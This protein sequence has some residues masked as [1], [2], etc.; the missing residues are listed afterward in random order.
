MKLI[1]L[2]LLTT[3]MTVYGVV[4]PRSQTPAQEDL[5]FSVEIGSRLY[6]D[7]AETQLVALGEDF[8]L[9][10]SE[11][12]AVVRDFLPDFRIND[13][14]ERISMT[15]E[16]NNPAA[17]IHVFSDSGVVDSTWAFMNFPPH[18][19]AKQFFT[20]KLLDVVGYETPAAEEK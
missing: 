20:F 7:W 16:L 11:Y 2:A 6:P 5:H 17:F 12:M 8:Y 3:A 10:D 1:V 15:Q 14:G 19:T 13:A 4:E 9:A 18:F